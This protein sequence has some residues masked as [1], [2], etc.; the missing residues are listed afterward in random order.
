MPLAKKAVHRAANVG[1]NITFLLFQLGLLFTA[2]IYASIALTSSKKVPDSDPQVAEA[3]K[4]LRKMVIFFW[5]FIGFL[6][7]FSLTIGFFLIPMLVINPFFYGI[8]MIL[9]S[10]LMF[11]PAIN[12]FSAYKKIKDSSSPDA[13]KA[14][15]TSMN[16]FIVVVSAIILMF[17]YAIFTIVYYTKSGGLKSDVSILAPIVGAD[18]YIPMAQEYFAPAQAPVP[19]PKPARMQVAQA[20]MMAPQ[21]APM[22]APQPA[23]QYQSTGA[24][25]ISAAAQG[26]GRAYQDVGGQQFL[27]IGAQ[28]VAQRVAARK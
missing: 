14:A 23:P 8:T 25:A 7:V 5:V 11:Y 4:Q 20:P 1:L 21:P 6:M 13:K 18:Q 26:L 9:I 19:P 12:L 17:A 15:K 3:K 28:Q 24:A 10:G 16:S 22:M 27:N 2:A